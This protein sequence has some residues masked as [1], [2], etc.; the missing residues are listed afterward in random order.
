MRWKQV[1][2]W[3]GWYEVSEHGDV[4]SVE[5]T[6]YRRDGT[7]QTWRGRN[8]RTYATQKGYLLVRLSRPDKRATERVHRLVALAFLPEAHTT[9]TIN[10]K[11][12]VKTNNAWSN[13]EWTTRRE[14]TLHS[15]ANNLG[16]YIPPAIFGMR[17]GAARLTPEKVAFIRSAIDRSDRSLAKELGVDKATIGDARRG[18]TWANMPTPPTVAVGSGE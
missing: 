7:V 17:N 12:G 9:E 16:N 8:L 13:L 4:R 1:V 14:N 5:R 10:H 2:G 15:I 6:S 3:E 11:D 18:V